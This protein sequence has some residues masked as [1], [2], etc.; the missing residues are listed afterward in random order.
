MPLAAVTQN[1]AV[2]QKIS[3]AESSET[4]APAA[5]ESRQVKKVELTLNVADAAAASESLTEK[6]GTCE[7]MGDRE[8]YQPCADE[9]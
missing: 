6:C 2:F 5:F 8:E 9:T 1:A 7:V 3:Q 4:Q